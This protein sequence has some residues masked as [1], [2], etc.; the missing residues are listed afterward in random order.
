MHHSNL[1]LHFLFIFEQSIT[2]LF[3]CNFSVHNTIDKDRQNVA[4]S[5]VVYCIYFVLRIIIFRMDGAILFFSPIYKL[6]LLCL[7]KAI[8]LYLQ[9]K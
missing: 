4:Q 3:V 2:K 1:Q 8:T 7:T 6:Q 9:T 5:M